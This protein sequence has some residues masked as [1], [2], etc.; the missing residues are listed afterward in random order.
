MVS[1]LSDPPFDMLLNDFFDTRSDWVLSRRKL[2]FSALP[3]DV[4]GELL[5]PLLFA[6]PYTL[7]L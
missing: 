4:W 3:G 5:D 1:H 6:L 2:L 7:S